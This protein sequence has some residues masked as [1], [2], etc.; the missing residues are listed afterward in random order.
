MSKSHKFHKANRRAKKFQR[1]F[2][3]WLSENDQRFVIPL[4][5]TG[6]TTRHIDLAFS[7][8]TA[9]I[10]VCVL[11][12]E[13]RVCVEWD[14]GCFDCLYDL[15]VYPKHTS[16]GYICELCEPDDP[17]CPLVYQ[18]REELWREHLYE[19]FLAWANSNLAAAR[20]LRLMTCWEA[21]GWSF[22]AARLL[23]D[24]HLPA[25]ADPDWCLL[26]GLKN[27]DGEPMFDRDEDK[28]EIRFVPLF[29]VAPSASRLEP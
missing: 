2:L 3:K 11:T 19:G 29:E 16:A 15:D 21:D 27:L 7:G 6:R 10:S 22:A 24:E 1:A 8:V 17:D 20:W 23:R 5:V 26:N 14:K 4:R 18:T 28:A 25:E 12:D 13:I 9:L